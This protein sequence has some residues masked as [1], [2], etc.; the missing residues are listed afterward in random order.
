MNKKVEC[1]NIL[2]DFIINQFSFSHK[3][4]KMLLTNNL[5]QVDGKIITKYNYQLKIGQI[6]NVNIYNKSKDI[7]IIYEDKDIIVINKEANL[8]TVS[9]GKKD[10]NLYALVSDYVKKNNKNNKIFIVHRLDKETSGVILFAKNEYI[11]NKLQNNWEE[12]ALKR[13]YVAIVLGKIKN[14]GILRH[15]LKEN[16]NH[17]VYVNKTGKLAIT[18]YQKIKENDKY[19]W[20]KII[21]ATGRKNQIRVQLKEIGNIILGDKKYGCHIPSKRM[22]LHAFKLVIIHPSTKKE[23]EFN[24]KIPKEFNCKIK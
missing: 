7:D 14:S 5:I 12:I 8:L 4:A 17:Y 22:F 16:E 2:I 20:L 23:I 10:I 6:V 1:E 19:S 11:K 21:I 13:E 24:A 15:Y 3:K 9:D 18:N